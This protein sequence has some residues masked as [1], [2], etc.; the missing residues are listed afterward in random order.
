MDERVS[1]EQLCEE[2]ER[3]LQF[4]VCMLS[5]MFLARDGWWDG[6]L[7][8][9]RAR[10]GRG[11]GG[12]GRSLTRHLVAVSRQPRAAQVSAVSVRIPWGPAP[13]PAPRPMDVFEE[14]AAPAPPRPPRAPTPVVSFAAGA[15]FNLSFFDPEPEELPAQP[16]GTSG[17]LSYRSA[18]VSPAFSTCA[19]SD[20]FVRITSPLP[21]V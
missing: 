18:L 6:G 9:W 17:L 19:L 21:G 2:C 20:R 12:G 10:C 1:A 4:V 15:D 5:T 14:T 13:A 3:M 7:A 11:W 16:P 8:G